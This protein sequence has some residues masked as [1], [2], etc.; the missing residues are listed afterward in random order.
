MAIHTLDPDK[1]EPELQ[2]LDETENVEDYVQTL[3]LALEGSNSTR[4][5]RFPSETLQ[6][7]KEIEG[8]VE[9]NDAA[10]SAETIASRLHRTQRQTQDRVR[11]TKLQKGSLLNCHFRIEGE[12]SDRVL[13]AKIEHSEFLGL[14]EFK[15][16]VGLPFEKQ[17][18]KAALGKSNGEDGKFSEMLLAD[19][20]S[21]IASFWWQDFLE[22]DPV[23]SD[24][25]NTT[26]AFN[27][28]DKIIASKLGKKSKA[29][30]LKIRNR[31]VEYFRGRTDFSF[32]DLKEALTEHYVSSAPDLDLDPLNSAIE[33][34]S[35]S[36]KF[37][38]N[39]GIDISKVKSRAVFKQVIP[40]SDSVDLHLK[41]DFDP[42]AVIEPFVE[43]GR[44]GI[45]ILSEVGY[46]YFHEDE[47]PAV[48]PEI[49]QQG[50]SE[51]QTTDA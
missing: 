9:G 19:S 38:T 32:G 36:G 48:A 30:H 22:L 51:N 13:L 1:E 37:D 25:E 28:V 3:V 16:R 26:A 20:N 46:D 7:K 35:E 4:Q 29:D 8:I 6:V 40:L 15:R 10:S 24:E 50:Q 42:G 17:V 43:S 33:K 5:Y 12:L 11:M 2:L 39:F 18:L 31:M 47:A 45:K 14:E 44:K 34:L 49:D 41:P 27:A 21:G 23:R